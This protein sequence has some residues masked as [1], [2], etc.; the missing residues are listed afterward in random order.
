MR[1]LTEKRAPERRSVDLNAI[2]EDAV[3]LTLIGH[4]RSVRMVRDY[5]EDLPSLVVDQVQIQQ[6]VV[7]LVRNA[8][9]AVRERR[10]AEIVVSTAPEDRH[11]LIS[12]SD[13]GPGIPPERHADLFRAFKT[14]KQSGMGLGLAISRTIVQSHGENFWLTRAG[15]DAGRASGR[16]ACRFPAIN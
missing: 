2:V 16:F 8:F 15:A 10:D 13:N 11:V 12:V 9:E 1:Q 4:D 14:G 6:V 7:N 3:D 5:R